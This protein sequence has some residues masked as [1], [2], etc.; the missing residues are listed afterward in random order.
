[1]TIKEFAMLCNCNPQTLRYYDKLDL[2]KPAEVDS[3]TGYRHYRE[4]QALDFIK[5]KNLQEADFS[6]REIKEL[7]L[8][9]DD[10][11][12]RA[13]E[14]KIEEQL[15]KL[16]QIRKIQTTYLSEK[17][18]MEAK[19]KELKEKVLE[20]AAK[21]DPEEEF[22][23]SK[24]YYQKLIDN[25]NDLFEASIQSM[26]QM[27]MDFKDVDFNAADWE[28]EEIEEEQYLNPLESGNY[29]VVY[30]KH[31]WNRTKEALAELPKL[32]EVEYMF[33][34]EVEKSKLGNMA[35]CNVILGYA[36]EENKGKT[37][38]LGCNCT[39]SKDGKNHFWL[40]K[41]K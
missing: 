39:E 16:E 20:S 29:V 37:L 14:R 9:S 25:V 10:E 40:L 11:I 13:F 38:Q 23:I 27:D 31:D 4:S 22:G 36:L 34:I 35:F 26:D 17:Q 32:D 12:Y 18:I 7:L 19:I 41:A 1:M 24:E 5:I 8:K 2:L 33:H 28:Y 21:Y 30:E 15:V 3:W 6:I